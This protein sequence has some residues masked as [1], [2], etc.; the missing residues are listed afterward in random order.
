VS[1]RPTIA[2]RHLDA[3]F[4]M[5]P[6]AA[7]RGRRWPRAGIRTW[8]HNAGSTPLF[9]VTFWSAPGVQFEGLYSAEPW[10]V[11]HQDAIEHARLV[12]GSHWRQG[13]NLSGQPNPDYIR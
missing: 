13:V 2:P 5:P 7:E 6:L 12:L 10:F 1:S 8:H 4:E 11:S 9:L 3:P